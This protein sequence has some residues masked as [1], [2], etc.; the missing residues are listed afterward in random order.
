[1]W[2]KRNII[3]NDLFYIYNGLKHEI[4]EQKIEKQ[5]Y[6]NRFNKNIGQKLENN[7]HKKIR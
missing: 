6:L 3:K 2:W 5:I 4:K 1:M 7:N